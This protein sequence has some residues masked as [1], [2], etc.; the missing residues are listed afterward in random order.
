MTL[1]KKLFNVYTS[2]EITMRDQN[3]NIIVVSYKHKDVGKKNSK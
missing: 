1:I 2:L 3:I